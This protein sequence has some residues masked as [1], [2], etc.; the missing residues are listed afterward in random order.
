M[1]SEGFVSTCKTSPAPRAIDASEPGF[2][3]K[4]R[5]PDSPSQTALLTTGDAF[6]L[7]LGKAGVATEGFDCTG[8][9]HF[10]TRKQ[11][12]HTAAR[13]CSQAAT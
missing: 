12:A 2:A 6:V 7:E 10:H 11:K 1:G 9:V 8:H 3:D 13:P 4:F 5:T